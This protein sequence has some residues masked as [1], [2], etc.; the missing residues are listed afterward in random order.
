[1]RQTSIKLYLFLFIVFLLIPGLSGSAERNRKDNPDSKK[2]IR[3]MEKVADWQIANQH[4]VKSHDL[5]WTN[6]TLYV[7]MMEWAKIA[8]N[9]K[10]RQWLIDIGRK[11]GWQPHHRMYNADDVVVCQMYLEM[12]RLEGDKQMFYPTQA[13]TEWVINHP[14]IANFKHGGGD[15]T[16]E[17]WTWCDAL[18]MAPPVYVQMYNLTGDAKYLDFFDREYH[19]TY[20]LLYDQKE[21]LFFRDHRYFDQK[22]KNGEKIFWGRGNGWVLGGLVKILKELPK[23]AYIRDFYENLFVEMCEKVVRLQDNDGY[24]HASLLD[25]ASYP[26]PETSSSGFFV[27]ALAYGINSGL[28]DKEQFLPSVRKGWA[29][30]E[31]A[32]FPDGKLGWV[33]PVGVD[34]QHTEK[35]MT[36]VYGVGAFLLAGAEV[37][38]LEENEDIHIK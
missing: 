13:R 12:Y 5:R 19:M 23:Y 15:V 31:N 35:D 2:I 24:W 3:I 17:R 9:G 34:P 26:N 36:E 18:F 32:V 38:R 1:M 11:H 28:L 30:L 16:S 27:Y 7:G 21:H 25:P 22:E 6:G 10:Y 20:N 14:S 8:E 33:Q 29:A 4:T 37:Y